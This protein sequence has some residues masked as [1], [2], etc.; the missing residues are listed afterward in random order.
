LGVNPIDVSVIRLKSIVA[1]FISDHQKKEQGS[2]DTDGQAEDVD[3][4]NPFASSEAAP[5]DF[6]VVAD[7]IQR[8]FSL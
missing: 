7:H 1:Q 5:G 4:A 3:K 6:E 2:R 8:V